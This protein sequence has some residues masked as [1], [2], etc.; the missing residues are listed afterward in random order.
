[1][2]GIAG[3]AT[4][5][6]AAPVDR[7]R[8]RAMAAT[9]AHRGPDDS[10]LHAGDGA[11]LVSRRLAVLDPAHGRQPFSDH[12][13]DVRAV[14]NGEIYNHRQLRAEL[15]G[16][17]CRFRSACDAEVVPHLYAAY[18]PAFVHRLEG[19]FALA[20]WDQRRRR[21][22]L[23]R[24]RLGVKPLYYAVQADTLTFGSEIK[25]LL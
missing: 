6:D 20:V 21:L 15:T 10:G 11:G 23:A 2:C 1:M 19:M 5:R 12:S 3:V 18:G 4:G 7:R 14:L 9:L 22:V 13:G 17:G 24:D 16:R 8:L 25:A